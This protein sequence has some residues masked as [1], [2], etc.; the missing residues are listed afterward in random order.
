MA[1]PISGTG[2]GTDDKGRIVYY[3]NGKIKRM[4]TEAARFLRRGALGIKKASDI[5]LDPYRRN[6]AESLAIAQRGLKHFQKTKQAIGDRLV[7]ERGTTQTI[8]ERKLE[9][10]AAEAL[11]ISDE[12]AVLKAQVEMDKYNKTTL[13]KLKKEERGR[14]IQQLEAQLLENKAQ[15]KDTKEDESVVKLINTD[16]DHVPSGLS[17]E[18]QADLKA[19]ADEARSGGKL[20]DLRGGG[21]NVEKKSYEDIIGMKRGKERDEL[22]IKHWEDQGYSFK[23][24]HKS[25]RRELANDLRIGHAAEH[26][27]S[28]GSFIHFKGFRGSGR[29]FKK[30]EV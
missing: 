30:N 12:N 17:E 5:A 21:G 10:K 16:R 18:E 11:M 23:G 14:T 28:K 2:Y 29:T 20:S 7:Y 1:K 22:T 13:D 8:R 4:G 6:Q 24:L 9:E 27:G 15:G 3:E 19:Q 26:T 25:Q